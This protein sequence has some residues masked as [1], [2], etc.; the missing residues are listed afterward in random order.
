MISFV[1]K[2]RRPSNRY[3]AWIAALAALGGFLFGFDTGVVGSAEPYFSKSL[4]IGSFGE[5]W[6]VGSLLI[7]AVAGAAASGWLADAISRKWTKC[8]AGCI[9]TVAALGSA[10]GP[11]V[12]LVCIAR[13]V[14][15]LAVGTASFVAPMYISEQSP[16]A[17]RG[18]MT[19]L[20]Q[21]MIALGIF[22][23][24][25]SDYA[26]SG[27]QHNWRWMFGVE[28]I[29]GAALALAMI[30][31]P[32]TPRW[33]VQ[34]GRDDE[35]REVLERTRP[36]DEVDD[37][38]DSIKD[39]FQRQRHAGIRELGRRTLRPFLV[40]GLTL[41]V[42]QQLVGINAVIYFGS[43]IMGF[44]GHKTNVA[45]YDAISLG[46]AN[47]AGAAA[48][49]LMLD[50]IG[51][52]KLLIA[53]T[54]GMTVALGA[55]GWYFST[56]SPFEHKQAWVGLV[57]VLVYLIAFEIS[58]GPVFWLMISELYP[59]RIRPKAMALATMVNWAFNFLV[60]YFFL[61]LTQTV[62]RNG[63]F[64]LFG[65]FALCALA[66]SALRVPETRGKSLEQIETELGGEGA[67]E[68]DR[69]A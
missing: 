34:K 23:A 20:N 49:A 43:T 28:A 29:P 1:T 5:S 63:T 64:W 6:V 21:V 24:Y 50:W 31:V 69:A 52:R 55:L 8:L 7:G 61:Q 22:I 44:M 16:K 40:I 67:A 35:A 30:F 62:G 27:L 45:V 38:L 3:V 47:F 53:G 4:G 10:F 56:S 11:N 65:F 14:L 32:H 68:E 36:E 18:G 66:F 12:E 41:A 15:G 51:R 54:A 19:A 48:A 2:I 60:S 57:C 25:L 39:V 42:L 46:A 9:F 26:L 17:L 37:E 59:L 33:L 58:L 13:F